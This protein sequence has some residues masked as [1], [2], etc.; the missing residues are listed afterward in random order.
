[1]LSGPGALPCFSVLR[2]MLSF[3]CE[4]ALDRSV[5]TLCAFDNSVT[6]FDTILLKSRSWLG[7][8]PFCMSFAAMQFSVTGDLPAFDVDLPLSV[9]SDCHALRLECVKPM[10]ETFSFHL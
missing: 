6:S 7:K 1:M 9:L 3:S 8:R 5:L 10:D 4:K 2:A